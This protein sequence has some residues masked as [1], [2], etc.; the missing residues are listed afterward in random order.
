MATENQELGLNE[1][2]F[3]LTREGYFLKTKFLQDFDEVSSWDSNPLFAGKIKNSDWL[4][5]KIG[6]SWHKKQIA[7]LLNAKSSDETIWFDVETLDDNFSSNIS[8]IK[9]GAKQKA[10][11]V[12]PL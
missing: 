10:V 12:E 11:M 6:S 7:R 9:F 8:Q 4:H 5:Y 1:F 2:Y 3:L